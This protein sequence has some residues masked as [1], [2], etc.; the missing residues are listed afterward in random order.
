MRSVDQ[1]VLGA[2][3]DLVREQRQVPATLVRHIVD[4]LEDVVLRPRESGADR[5]PENADAQLTFAFVEMEVPH[6]PR[7]MAHG[8]RHGSAPC[9]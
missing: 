2:I 8:S 7:V 9:C 4:L 5:A 3:R 6:A 1:V